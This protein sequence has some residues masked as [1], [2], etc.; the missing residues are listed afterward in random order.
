MSYLARLSLANRALVALGTVAIVLLGVF[1]ARAL[2]QELLPS[3]NLPSVTVVAPY[4]GAAPPIVERDVAEPIEQQVQA[5]EPYQDLTSESQPGAAVVQVAYDFGTDTEEVVRD[6]QQRL[7]QAQLPDE[8]DPSVQSGDIDDLPVVMLAATTPGDQ[9]ELADRLQEQADAELE[10]IEGVRQSSVSGLRDRVVRVTMNPDDLAD[11]GLTTR[12]VTSAL[13]ANES[14]VPGGDV[15]GGGRTLSV[16][17]GGAFGSVDE[18]RSLPIPA[19]GGAG[20]SPGGG[21]P[22]GPAGGS[23][24]GPPSDAAGA[25][26]ATGQAGAAQSP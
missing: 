3:Q 5:G 16:E 13:T 11:E 2:N 8:V 17:V 20:A 4:E 15:S 1:A 25:A 26:G 24:Q 7:E 19:S 9:R 10:S 12:Q 14:R 22:G 18:I 23:A 6:L 21:A